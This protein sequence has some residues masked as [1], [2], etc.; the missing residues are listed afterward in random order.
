MV[1]WPEEYRQAEEPPCSVTALYTAEVTPGILRF[2]VRSR[3][4]RHVMQ[5]IR[6]LTQRA[7]RRGIPTG[8]FHKTAVSG[9][10]R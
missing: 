5:R 9:F 1:G 4:L 3:K 8:P 6:Y 2:L 7:R 10:I